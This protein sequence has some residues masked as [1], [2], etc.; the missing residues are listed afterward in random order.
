[1]FLDSRSAQ[2][3]NKLDFAQDPSAPDFAD[4]SPQKRRFTLPSTP[5]HYL[6]WDL[7]SLLANAAEVMSDNDDESQMIISDDES[8]HSDSSGPALS[9]ILQATEDN[10]VAAEELMPDYS[11]TNSNIDAIS[12]EPGG[13]ATVTE[14]TS[15]DFSPDPGSPVYH[16]QDDAEPIS[17]VRS[18]DPKPY[19]DITTSPTFRSEEVHLPRKGFSHLNPLLIVLQSHMPC[20]LISKDDIYLIQRPLDS[21]RDH[22]DLVQTMRHPLHP[23][24]PNDYIGHYDRQC[25]HTQIPEL[26]VFIIGSPVGR[27]A[28]FS[29][30][31]LRKPRPADHGKSVYGYGFHLE[32]ILPF[33]AHDETN[34]WSS[35]T[36]PQCPR[37]MLMGVA[38]GPVQGMFDE[39]RENGEVG[40]RRDR[41]WRLLMYYTDHSV[42]S[43]EI[44]RK[45]V[46]QEPGLG[47]LVV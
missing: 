19:C 17:P 35:T 37:A 33:S 38:V 36:H 28:I 12:L 34:I 13:T 5:D 10:D 16:P 40:P 47:D 30:T 42:L 25:F 45:R 24:D 18:F 39:V 4:L 23:Q 11:N 14:A 20:L 9:P 31:K 7:D 32:Y 41:R 46:G 1:M 27:A 21:A 2:E 3:V 15:S 22:V 44:A 26:G 8:S 29:L 6:N 43:F